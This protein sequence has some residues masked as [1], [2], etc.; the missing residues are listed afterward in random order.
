MYQYTV[1]GDGVVVQIGDHE[2]IDLLLLK[3]DLQSHDRGG[4]AGLGEELITYTQPTCLKPAALRFG[5]R[6][7]FFLNEPICYDWSFIESVSFH[8]PEGMFT[9]AGGGGIGGKI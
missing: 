7:S 2:I 1:F 3:S 8:H 4:L 5:I 6:I 9:G